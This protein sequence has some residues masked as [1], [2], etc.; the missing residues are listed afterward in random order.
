MWFRSFINAAMSR[1]LIALTLVVVV[2]PPTLSCVT[3]VTSE[4]GGQ[5]HLVQYRV[6]GA[7]PIFNSFLFFHLELRTLFLKVSP[8]LNGCVTAS[9]LR[10]AR[11]GAS[12][13]S[14][15]LYCRI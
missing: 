8:P 15:Q 7:N 5:G 12:A 4:S 11:H 6:A 14:T 1:A 3:W 9:P 13:R 2:L 10:R